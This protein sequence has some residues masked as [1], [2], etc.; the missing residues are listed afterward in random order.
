ME[1]FNA[2]C[3]WLQFG[4]PTLGDNDPE[5]LE[6]LVKFRLFQRFRGSFMPVLAAVGIGRRR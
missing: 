4:N 5:H 6:K 1:S 2:F 3:Q